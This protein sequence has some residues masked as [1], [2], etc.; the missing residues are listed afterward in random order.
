M[1]D[2]EGD[3]NDAEMVSYDADHEELMLRTRLENERRQTALAYWVAGGSQ[4]QLDDDCGVVP[5]PTANDDQRNAVDDGATK[6]LP[7][8]F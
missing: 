3:Y 7:V 8:S 1:S 2:S 6:M 4:L 5:T